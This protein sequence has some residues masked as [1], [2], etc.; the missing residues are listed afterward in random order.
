M[1]VDE[2]DR[3]TY[4]WHALLLVSSKHKRIVSTGKKLKLNVPQAPA[5]KSKGKSP[6]RL[7]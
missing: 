4:V 3:K 1:E 5:S 7:S 2:L 6:T